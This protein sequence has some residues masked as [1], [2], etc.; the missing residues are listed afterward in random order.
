MDHHI[1]GVRTGHRS[2]NRGGAGH[3]LVAGI[4]VPVAVLDPAVAFIGS[5]GAWILILVVVFG[6]DDLGRL[7]SAPA[8]SP[9]LT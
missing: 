7:L 5:I 4:E 2:R 3:E 8:E 1:F 9:S 6:L